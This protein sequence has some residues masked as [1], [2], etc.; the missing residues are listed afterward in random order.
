[1]KDL[2]VTEI[3]DVSGS[4]PAS[5]AAGLMVGLTSLGIQLY[6]NHGSAIAS[7]AE[8]ASTGYANFRMRT[9]MMVP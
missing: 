4:G 6:D 2:S 9:P 7:A 5:E 8:A 3:E 1:M